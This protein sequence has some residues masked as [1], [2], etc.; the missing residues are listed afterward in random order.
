MALFELLD[1]AG[2]TARAVVGRDD[3]GD[4]VAVVVK[5]RRIIGVGLVAR[6]A[7]HAFCG[8]RA[9][10][11]LLD[12][13]RRRAGMALQAGFAFFGNLRRVRPQ[14]G[15]K[16]QCEQGSQ[17]KELHGNLQKGARGAIRRRA[18]RILYR[19]GKKGRDQSHNQ[20][21]RADWRRCRNRRT[22]GSR[23]RPMAIS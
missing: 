9:G 15:G 5:G 22:E 11:P 3:D 18:S 7:V 21:V 17:P 23:S 10:L 8:V 14:R 12:D 20:S 4:L 6:K 2:V 1:F 13:S 16:R 19:H